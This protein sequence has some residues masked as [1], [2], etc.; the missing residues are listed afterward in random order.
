MKEQARA[1]ALAFERKDMGI[2]ILGS[3]GQGLGELMD[4]RHK[5]GTG[6]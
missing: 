4:Q 5:A 6:L 3:R 1:G 2:W